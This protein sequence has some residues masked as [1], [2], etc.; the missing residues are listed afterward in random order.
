MTIVALRLVELQHGALI[1][2]KIASISAL[3]TR[4]VLH[5]NSSS[6]IGRS[7]LALDRLN[8]LEGHR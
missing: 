5:L 3:S 7:F 8:L 4:V 1:L 2:S 6:V